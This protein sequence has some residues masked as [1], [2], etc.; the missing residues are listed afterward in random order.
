M[1]WFRKDHVLSVS[2]FRP[3]LLWF[4]MPDLLP[5]NAF[6]PFDAPLTYINQRVH[7]KRCDYR[8]TAYFHMFYTLGWML[9]RTSTRGQLRVKAQT[10]SFAAAELTPIPIQPPHSFSFVHPGNKG[11]QLEIDA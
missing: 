5:S 1:P 2:H 9:S 7:F 10:F 4:I 6:W 8:Y 3:R 11:K